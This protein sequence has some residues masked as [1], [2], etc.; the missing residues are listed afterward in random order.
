MVSM[1]SWPSEPGQE[2]LWITPKR[3]IEI[4]DLWRGQAVSPSRASDRRLACL[5]ADTL[6]RVSSESP[7]L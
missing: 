6:A 7:P 2:T 3:L 5:A 1:I 4:E